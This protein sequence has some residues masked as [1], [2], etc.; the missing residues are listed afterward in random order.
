LLP[1]YSGD[2]HY[3]PS[4][5]WQTRWLSTG[6][7][8]HSPCLAEV[9]G[10]AASP[11]SPSP[12]V[13]HTHLSSTDREGCGSQ[14]TKALLKK[15]PLPVRL[16]LTNA[17][18]FNQFSQEKLHLVQNSFLHGAMFHVSSAQV[19]RTM[20]ATADAMWSGKQ[21]RY[22]KSRIRT[23]YTLCPPLLLSQ[24]H[25]P[26]TPQGHPMTSTDPHTHLGESNS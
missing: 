19:T 8:N 9:V 2:K 23:R 4:R 7:R 26:S 21:Y 14:R 12:S 13:L 15:Y 11:A 22:W 6:S 10:S 5:I 1:P 17:M 25:H 20:N 3:H 24:L 18:L 16:W